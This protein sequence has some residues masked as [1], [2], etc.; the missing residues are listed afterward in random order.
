MHSS[1]SPKHLRYGALFT[2]PFEKRRVTV[3]PTEPY[4]SGF[5]SLRVV[6]GNAST[7]EIKAG[8]RWFDDN[9]KEV[10]Q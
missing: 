1:A 9:A 5:V 10:K 6:K 4:G 2:I 8:V 7:D 3:T